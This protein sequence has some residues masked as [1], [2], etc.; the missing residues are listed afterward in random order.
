MGALV[1]SDRRTG[2]PIMS[3]FHIGGGE[4]ALTVL[5]VEFRKALG[6]LKSK[7]ERIS[8]LETTEREQVEEEIARCEEN[9]RNARASLERSLF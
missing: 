6:E 9:F 1:T 5:E 3:G 8:P 4:A 2:L 7:L